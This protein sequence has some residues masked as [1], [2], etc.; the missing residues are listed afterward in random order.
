MGQA[1]CESYTIA[2]YGVPLKS[3]E[4]G[5]ASMYLL[6]QELVP[7]CYLAVTRASAESSEASCAYFY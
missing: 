6:L 1:Q 3:M 2:N 7:G 5:P 4:P